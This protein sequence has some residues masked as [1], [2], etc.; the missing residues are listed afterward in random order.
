MGVASPSQGCEGSPR[1]ATPHWRDSPV[2]T[3]LTVLPSVALL[4]FA[5]V[6]LL[7]LHAAACILAWV[8]EAGARNAGP[9]CR[10][11]GS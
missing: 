6:A 1:D 8:G 9:A 4:A 10:E 2:L 3:V 5:D 7:R 11:G